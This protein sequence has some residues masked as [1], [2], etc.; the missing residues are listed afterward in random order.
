MSHDLTLIVP[1]YDEGANFVALWNSIVSQIHSSFLVLVVYDFDEDDTV[2]VVQQIIATGENRLSMVKN[3][4]EPGVV[5]AIRTGFNNVESGPVLVVMAD[6]CDDLSQ[7]D[8]MLS[9]YREGYDVVVASRY[10]RGGKIINGRF[11]KQTLSRIAGVTLH[12]LRGIPTDDATN[13]FKLYD[14]DML[15][16]VQIESSAGFELSLELTV[17]A[18]LAGYRIVEFPTCWRERMVGQSRFRIWAWLPHYLRWYLHAFRPRQRVPE[19][20]R[21]HRYTLTRESPPSLER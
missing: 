15:K 11:V 6:L 13:A 21:P 14:S 3:Q 19:T 5:G 8:T 20:S 18:F 12:W 17:K 16:K 1:V 9:L 2:P 10:M 4:L 7:V